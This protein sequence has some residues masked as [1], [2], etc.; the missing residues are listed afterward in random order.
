MEN[1]TSNPW[2]VQADFPAEETRSAR[3]EFLVNYAVLAPSSHNI[4]PWL[5]SVRGDALEMYADRSQSL[6]IC[7]P[8]DRELTISCGAALQFARLAARNFGREGM[9]ELMPN[10]ANPDLLA[11]LRLGAVSPPTTAEARRFNAIPHR[12]VVRPSDD[13]TGIP[14]LNLRYLSTLAAT[15]GIDF[16]ASSD[17]DVRERIASLVVQADRRQMQDPSFRRELGRWMDLP[18]D[19]ESNETSANTTAINRQVSRAASTV[20]RVFNLVPETVASHE[21]LVTNSPWLGLFSSLSDSPKIW[22]RTGMA[23][24]DVF[25]ELT[26]QGLSCSFVDQPIE[27]S[28]TRA[29]VAGTLHAN[30]LAQML[31]RVGKGAPEPV[32]ARLE[33]KL[34]NGE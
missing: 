5:F 16:T 2:H 31:M 8:C 11:R 13:G 12:H 17:P 7:D 33:A 27:V 21:Y 10:P 4:H 24:A 20:M 22:L 15:Y 3:L 29:E 18:P 6:P 23:L 34:V 25:L 28:E 19:S 26:A 14:E 1:E 32:G 9:V 30:G